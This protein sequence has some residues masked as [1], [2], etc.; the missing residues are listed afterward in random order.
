MATSEAREPFA[1][2]ST[3]VILSSRLCV[4]D[5][6]RVTFS[7]TGGVQ[8]C[9]DDESRQLFGPFGSGEG[10]RGTLSATADAVTGVELGLCRS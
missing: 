8:A 4:P 9:V 1:G 7:E 3:V 5:E 10:V 6:F 2:Q